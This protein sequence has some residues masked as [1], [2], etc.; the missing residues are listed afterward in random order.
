MNKLSISGLALGFGFSWGI[1]M[2]LL[3][4]AAGGLNWG[5][6]LVEVF[7]SLYIGYG[8]TF[9]GGIIG[10]LWGFVDGAIGGIFVAAFYNMF[11][12]Q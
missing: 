8:P 9:W 5:N 10:A 2:L 3:G 6:M 7:S 1:G 12:G 11:C 4:W